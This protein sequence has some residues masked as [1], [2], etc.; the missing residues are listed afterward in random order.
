MGGKCQARMKI[1]PEERRTARKNTLEHKLKRYV[2]LRKCCLGLRVG[3]QIPTSQSGPTHFHL[4]PEART[5]PTQESLGEGQ[6]DSAKEFP[7]HVCD[8]W[9]IFGVLSNI[10]VVSCQSQPATTVE[11]VI[12]VLTRRSALP[13]GV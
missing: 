12:M 1:E 3:L 2:H 10:I 8:N 4:I 6:A 13:S 7:C 11:R 5:G 9:V